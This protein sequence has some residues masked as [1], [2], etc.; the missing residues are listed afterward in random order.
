MNCLQAEKHFSAHFEDA[1]DYELLQTFEDHLAGCETCQQEYTRFQASVKVVQQLPQVEPSPYFM[2]LL[3]ERLAAEPIASGGVKEIAAIGW[4]R[5]LAALRRP[6]WA[7]SGITALILAVGGGYLYQE[8][9]LF[10]DDIGS[11]IVAPEAQEIQIATPPVPT[12]RAVGNNGQILPR[13]VIST[14]Q[15]PLQRHYVLKQVSYTNAS[16]RGGL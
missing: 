5:L 9:F 15:R 14:Q 13:N 12:G 10:D 3:Q 6:V 2:P 4:K 8:G 7:F 11:S 1:L 16:T